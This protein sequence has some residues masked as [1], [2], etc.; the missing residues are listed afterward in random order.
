MSQIPK[1]DEQKLRA[2]AQHAA[3]HSQRLNIVNWL[4]NTLSI[5]AVGAPA[6]AAIIGVIFFLHNQ[7]PT[8]IDTEI[9]FLELEIMALEELI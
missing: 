9:L 6:F 7:Q 5:P 2:M 8:E 3:S 4:K 1:I